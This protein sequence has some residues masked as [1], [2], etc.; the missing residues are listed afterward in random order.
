[1]LTVY[2]CNT[3]YASQKLR[4]Y[5]AEKRIEWHSHHIDLRKQ[6]HITSDYRKINPKGT[7]PP[8]KHDDK[9]V[10][11]STDIMLYLEEKYPEPCLLTK[12]NPLRQQQI[13]FCYSHEALHDPSIR[14]LSYVNIFMNE[15]NQKNMDVA[16]ILEHAK[17]HPWQQRGDFLQ[18]VLENKITDVEIQQAKREIINALQAMEDIL[19]SS[20]MLFTDTYSI[21]DAIA[22]ATLFRIE[23]VGLTAEIKKFKFLNKYYIRLQQRENFKLANMI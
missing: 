18:R 15:D 20:D 9:I 23:K 12:K 5:L 13:D 16:Q 6:E 11:G 3:S 19:S 2:H 8:I 7:V 10:C 22:C 4:L 1:M 14:L 17:N 21:A